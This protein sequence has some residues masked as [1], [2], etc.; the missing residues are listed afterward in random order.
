MKQMGAAKKKIPHGFCFTAGSESLKP[1]RNVALM[2]VLTL[3]NGV[4]D[5]I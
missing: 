4:P 2:E 1:P 5:L 3:A